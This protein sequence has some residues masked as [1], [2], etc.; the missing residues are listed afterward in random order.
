MIRATVAVERFTETTRRRCSDGSFA[1]LT[2]T[3]AAVDKPQVLL[4]TSDTRLDL[5]RRL[6][7]KL[8]MFLANRLGARLSRYLP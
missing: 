7:S 6:W 3:I 1:E 8:P 5:P 2:T 4:K